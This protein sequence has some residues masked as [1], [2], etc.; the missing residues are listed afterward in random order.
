MARKQKAEIVQTADGWVI[1]VNGEQ[2][3]DVFETEEDATTY[4]LREGCAVEGC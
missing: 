2:W 3:I 4:A 1:V